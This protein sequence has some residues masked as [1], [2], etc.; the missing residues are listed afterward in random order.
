MA[1]NSLGRALYAPLLGGPDSKQNTARF[2]FLNP[3]SRDFLPDWEE[4]ADAIAATLRNYVGQNPDDKVL[5][6]LIAELLECS[7]AFRVRWDQHDV[8]HHRAGPKRAND[9]EV[10]E[11]EFSYQVMNLPANPEVEA[12]V[13][14]MVRAGSSAGFPQ[15]TDVTDPTAFKDVLDP[16]TQPFTG[17][18][19]RVL[20]GA[21]A[22]L[23]TT[24]CGPLWGINRRTI[25]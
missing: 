22:S 25:L 3:A 2:V 8:R 14:V 1:A 9:P 4:N 18:P 7:E 13:R 11:M 17:E 5:A 20:A 23:E 10:G 24:L 19:A 12:A 21:S 16:D 15:S 6:A